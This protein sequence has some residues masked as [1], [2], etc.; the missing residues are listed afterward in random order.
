[1]ADVLAVVTPVIK[2]FLMNNDINKL[3]NG[4][5]EVVPSNQV[6]MTAM[7]YLKK[8]GFTE[9]YYRDCI[10]HLEYMYPNNKNTNNLI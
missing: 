2:E 6:K 10:Y 7:E 3:D 9:A 4:D 8:Y 1:M 5:F